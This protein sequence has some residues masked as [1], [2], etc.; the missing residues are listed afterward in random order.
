MLISSAILSEEKAQKEL[1]VLTTLPLD[2]GRSLQTASI[3]YGD[4]KFP[5][6]GPQ[7]MYGSAAI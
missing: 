7:E 2:T 5:L 4:Q 3:I 1:A 6:A